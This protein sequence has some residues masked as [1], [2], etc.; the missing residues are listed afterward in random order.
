MTVIK[1]AAV[2]LSPVLYSREGTVDKVVQKI[3]E[4]GLQGVQFA[5]FP[6]TV[7]PYYP[8]FALVQAPY[9]MGA[10]HHRLLEQ[11]V[12]VPS[13]ATHAIGEACRQAGMV[14]SI[15]VNERDGGTIYNTQLLFDAD[16]SL[17]QRRRKISPTYHERLIWGQGDGSG[18]RAVDSAVGR[19]GQLACWEHYNPLARYALMADGEQIHSAMYPGSFAGDIFSEQIQV[20]IR[21][22]ALESGCFVVNATAWLDADQQAQIMKDTGCPVGPISSGCFTAIVSPDG[23]LMG[24]PLRSGEGEVIADLDFALIDKR[25]QMMDSRGHYSRP[26]LLSLLIDRTPTAHVHERGAHPMPVAVEKVSDV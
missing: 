3:I 9:V 25:K 11:S 12:T 19:I 20:N 26:E 14:V 17:I 13:A 1:A 24:E 5:T 15:G 10:E 8:Y 16:G 2:Q 23:Q 7:V 6:E 22:H 18:L 4:L 21:Q